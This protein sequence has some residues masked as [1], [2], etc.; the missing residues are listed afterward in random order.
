MVF[1]TT[2]TFK[3]QQLEKLF[4]SVKWESGKYPKSLK[5][6]MK[7]SDTVISAW[8]N[9]ELVGLMNA[10][11]DGSMN[12]FFPY[13]LINPKYQGSG[14]GKTIIEKMLKCYENYFRKSLVCYSDKLEFYEKFGFK[15]DEGRLSL[16][17]EKS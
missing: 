17:I 3:K 5:L 9:G 8:E 1:K 13:L 11:S 4:L 2:K 16:T 15:T 14:I 12:V 6:A 7:K 10:I